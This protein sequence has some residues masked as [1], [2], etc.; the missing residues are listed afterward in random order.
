MDRADL[1]IELLT[2]ELPAKGLS[3]LA[4]AFVALTVEALKK[5][6]LGADWRDAEALWTP[7]RL[8]VLVPGLEVAQAEQVTERRG[9]ALAAGLDAEGKP[10]KA[11]AGFAASCGVEVAA[12]ERLETDKGSWFVHRA[13]SPGKRT[14]EVLPEVLGEVVKALPVAK[15]MRW[16]E[17]EHAFL[18]PVHGLLVLLGRDVVPVSMFGVSSGATTRGHRFVAA[19]P[20]VIEHPDTYVQ[21]LRAAKVIV[22]PVE[23][24]REIRDQ[25]RAKAMRARGTPQ[26]REELVD[27]VANLT[28]WPV[29]LLC[30]IPAEFMRLPDAVIISTIESHQKFF[31]ILDAAGKLLP[32]FIGVANLDSRDPQEIRKGYERVTRP[33][34]AD[35]AFFFDRDLAT[36][37]AS[38]QDGLRKVTFQGRLGSQWDKTLRVTLLAESLCS[39]FGV[40]AAHAQQAAS[41]SRCDLLSQMVGEFPELQ[42]KMGRTYCERQG[43]DPA[44]ALALDE[45]YS[46]RGAGQ[47]IATSK[48]GQLLAV[49]ERLD[50]LA[51]IF[52]IGQKP[53]GNKDPFSL[54]RSALGL[55]RTLIEG[56]VRIDLRAALTQAVTAVLPVLTASR[57]PKDAAIPTTAGL[58]DELFGFILDRLR[59]YYADAGVD[60]RVFE[61][62]AALKL[63]E[64]N[65]FDARAK[66]C[67]AFMKL[68]AWESLAAANKRIRNI[69]RKAEGEAVGPVD[70]AALVDPAEHA[71]HEATRAAAAD[72]APLKAAGLHVELLT[73]LAQLQAPVNAFFDGVMVMADDARLRRNRLG[74][75]KDLQDQFLQVADVSLLASG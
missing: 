65:D 75:L 43:G 55:A 2:E 16:G 24:A 41:L 69:L 6:G 9:P 12:L 15:P 54:R 35:A 32:A 66:A 63:D 48:L 64:L 53:T 20:I 44:V 3:E 27:E 4:Q 52:G 61:A 45:V 51:G 74:L 26:M 33:R 58:V 34:L 72:T 13:R 31:P 36:P 28:E 39:A 7:R 59:A 25:S 62:V 23:R 42:G 5:R 37:L 14:A 19:D 11:L 73:R 57:G 40:D 47:A 38:Y 67:V 60:A 10:S 29:P 21:Q 8:T 49:A 71:L 50:T 70:P 22:D 46:P 18:R 1:L 30:Q 17:G 56:G 68:P